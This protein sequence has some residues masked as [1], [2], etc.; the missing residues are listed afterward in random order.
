METIKRVISSHFI[1]FALL[2]IKNY[3][4]DVNS[5]HPNNITRAEWERGNQCHTLNLRRENKI[6]ISEIY[7]IIQFNF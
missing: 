7:N 4:H 1:T 2:T 6:N 5:K 3:Y